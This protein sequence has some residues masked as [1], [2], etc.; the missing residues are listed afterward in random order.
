[1]K[2]CE[3]AVRV[4]FPGILKH[5]SEEYRLLDLPRSISW[6][7][8]AAASPAPCLMWVTC[9]SGLRFTKWH[10]EVMNFGQ[11]MKDK[12]ETSRR[13][14]SHLSIHS[15]VSPQGNRALR[16]LLG[17]G[18]QICPEIGMLEQLQNQRYGLL[19]ASLPLTRVRMKEVEAYAWQPILASPTGQR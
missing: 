14:K 3:L 9:C 16:S 13:I 17:F 5:P 18:Y 12:L 19:S 1:M 2:G 8:I 11:H 15:W 7:A 10:G 6:A 4:V